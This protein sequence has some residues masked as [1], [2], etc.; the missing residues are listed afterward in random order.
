MEQET[1]HYSSAGSYKERA[2]STERGDA[3]NENKKL[4]LVR[5]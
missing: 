1:I 2:F 3:N 5:M 4:P